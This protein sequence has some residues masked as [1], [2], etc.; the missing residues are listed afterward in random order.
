MKK[1]PTFIA[2]FEQPSFRLLAYNI[3]D[4]SPPGFFLS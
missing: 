2:G 1:V 3:P 4:G